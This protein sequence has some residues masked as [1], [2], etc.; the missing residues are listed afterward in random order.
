VFALGALCLNWGGK[1][2]PVWWGLTRANSCPALACRSPGSTPRVPLPWGGPRC[3]PFPWGSA[4]PL[5]TLSLRAKPPRRAPSSC[6]LLSVR[7]PVCPCPPPGTLGH[8]LLLRPPRGGSL[9]PPQPHQG[10]LGHSPIQ[11]SPWGQARPT[12]GAAPCPPPGQYWRSLGEGVSLPYSDHQPCQPRL[13]GSGAPSRC[14]AASARCVPQFPLFFWGG[15]GHDSVSLPA[16]CF[17]TPLP[18][19]S[20]PL[21]PGSGRWDPLPRAERRPVFM[22]LHKR[23]KTRQSVF[24]LFILVGAW[25]GLAPLAWFFVINISVRPGPTAVPEGGCGGVSGAGPR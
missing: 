17:E 9:A 12:Y 19:C 7:E 25:G 6:V 3:P 21:R 13:R 1:S 8:C 11:P 18:R 24:Y 5:R 23:L 10:G 16:K 22:S 2:E 14:Q 20:P 15:R 4:R